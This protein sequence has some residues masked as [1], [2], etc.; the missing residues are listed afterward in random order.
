MALRKAGFSG[1]GITAVQLE[2]LV[3]V[4]HCS[5]S[6]HH[7]Q[8][9]GAARFQESPDQQAC[10]NE[11]GNVEPRC[12]VPYDGSF[13]HPRVTLCGNE[14]QSPEYQFDNKRRAR[15]RRVEGDE[16]KSSHLQPVIFAIDVQDPEN[17]QI[18][19]DECDQATETD[20]AVP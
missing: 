12:V 15:H 16:Q 17:D 18:S 8:H 9:R 19:K 14:T 11:K 3:S 4:P 1:Y 20:A 13:S 5:R 6:V 2:A 10:E 7:A